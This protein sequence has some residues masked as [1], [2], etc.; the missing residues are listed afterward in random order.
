MHVH[1][2]RIVALPVSSLLPPSLALFL[3]R[4]SS[5]AVDDYFTILGRFRHAFVRHTQCIHTCM[6]LCLYLRLRLSLSLSLCMCFH[7]QTHTQHTNIGVSRDATDKQVKLA[8]RQLALQYH[9]DKCRIHDPSEC[10]RR[11]IQ[12]SLSSL[13]LSLSRARALSLSL[14][15]PIIS[16]LIF[17]HPLS[18]SPP[19]LLILS[20]SLLS[21]SLTQDALTQDS[22]THSL[23]PFLPPSSLPHPPF[24]R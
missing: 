9:P 10:Q 5:A 24:Q 13:S 14:Q 11:F 8:Y 19:P 15:L 3:V 16:S 6:H 2:G 22:L 12:V 17:P 21:F 18:L 20:L 23:T 4:P 1:T 7:T